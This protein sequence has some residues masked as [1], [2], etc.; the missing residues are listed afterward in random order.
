LLRVVK[1]L[2]RLRNMFISWP[3]RERAEETWTKIEQRCQFPKVIGAIDG[4]LVKITAPKVHPEAY[5]CR[6]NYH[7]IQLQVNIELIIIK[8]GYQLQIFNF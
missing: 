7:A 2:Y 1:A 3:T 8:S 4:T 6:K 5:V